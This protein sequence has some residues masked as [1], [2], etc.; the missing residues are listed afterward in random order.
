MNMRIDDARA[1]RRLR[2]TAKSSMMAGRPVEMAAS[3]S[4]SAE[5][6]KR[7]LAAVD[8]DGQ[9]CEAPQQD[10]RRT[11][12]VGIAKAPKRPEGLRVV[13]SSDEPARRFRAEVDLRGRLA[14]CCVAVR[15]A[16]TCAMTKIAGTP[17]EASMMRQFRPVMFAGSGTR[18][19]AS[20]ETVPSMIP[21]GTNEPFSLGGR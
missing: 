4:I 16:L 19:K 17:A 14:V 20:E 18:K 7:S 8:V 10:K 1:A 21:W 12:D 11:L 2:A 5:M 13:A 9:D 6:R 3:S 15:S